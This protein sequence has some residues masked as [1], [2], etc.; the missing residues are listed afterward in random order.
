MTFSHQNLPHASGS[1]ASPGKS[2]RVVPG[3]TPWEPGKEA[4]LPPPPPL[5]TVRESFP[6]YSS[7]LHKRPSRD[8][9][10]S[11]RLS[12]TWICR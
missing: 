11:V 4:A 2:G 1:R 3:I 12:C 10:A 6:S 8:A 9:V 7:S 5:R